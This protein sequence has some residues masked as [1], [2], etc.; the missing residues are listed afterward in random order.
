MVI[1][2]GVYLGSEKRHALASYG[3]EGEQ[4]LPWLPTLLGWQPASHLLVY[5][6]PSKWFMGSPHHQ[7]R[8]VSNVKQS[9][10]WVTFSWDVQ[11]LS[12][13]LVPVSRGSLPNVSPVNFWI[14]KPLVMI[15]DISLGNKVTTA[16]DGATS[17][18]RGTNYTKQSFSL[19]LTA[20][21]SWSTVR[22][23][24]AQMHRHV[25]SVLGHT[26][27]NNSQKHQI[28]IEIKKGCDTH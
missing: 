16:A 9:K 14:D 6:T 22:S 19:I 8:F 5:Q 1:F 26:R 20:R 4:W 27:K 7:S 21:S 3:L 24:S 2:Q 11:S 28:K 13:H 25:D 10:R 23:C 15:W 18:I 12:R 17:A